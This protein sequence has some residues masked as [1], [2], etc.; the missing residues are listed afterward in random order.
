MG[1]YIQLHP[2]TLSI[3]ARSPRGNDQFLS[4]WEDLLSDFSVRF[5]IILWALADLTNP[6]SLFALT[7]R[8]LKEKR[9]R[10]V[11]DL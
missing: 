4:P 3:C 2:C 9:E 7:A 11:C 10:C 8:K 5:V 6:L 1:V